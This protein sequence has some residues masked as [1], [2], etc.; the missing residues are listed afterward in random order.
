MEPDHPLYGNYSWVGGWPA[1]SNLL[2]R[3]WQQEPNMLAPDGS[4]SERFLYMKTLENYVPYG[5][6][7]E[8]LLPP[9]YYDEVDTTEVTTLQTNI[10]T[11]VDES[12]ARFVVGTMSVDRDWDM[13]QNNLK[14]LGLDRYLQI[15]QSAYDRS[16][17]KR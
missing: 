4:G 6:P 5:A 15:T 17:L 1:Y 16:P 9:L 3:E 8:M 13:F 2:A 12:I 11:Y 14:N 7:V 10:N